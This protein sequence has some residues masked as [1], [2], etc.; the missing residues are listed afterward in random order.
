MF[1]F[2]IVVFFFSVVFISNASVKSSQ[3]IQKR[4][5]KKEINGNEKLKVIFIHSTEICVPY[6][7]NTYIVAL[8][9]IAR[10][11]NLNYR[12][13]I[14]LHLK[15][16]EKFFTWFH[17]NS[18]PRLDQVKLKIEINTRICCNRAI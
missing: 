15:S 3:N 9:C 12:G 14:R 7:S 6:E 5:K 8:H 13:N 1:W 2:L 18:E 4:R 11:F 10:D 17:F 16:N